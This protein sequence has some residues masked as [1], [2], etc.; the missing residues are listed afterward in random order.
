MQLIFVF[1]LRNAGDLEAFVEE[2]TAG[3]SKKELLQLY[4]IATD[5]PYSFLFVKLNAKK[6]EDMF[7]LRFEKNLY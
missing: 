2:V 5:E 7:Y 3:A 4:Q 6:V 1:K